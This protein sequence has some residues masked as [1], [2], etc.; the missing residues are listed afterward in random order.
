M[1]T[2]G[3]RSR[4]I[5]AAILIAMGLIQ[6]VNSMFLSAEQSFWLWLAGLLGAALALGWG[7]AQEKQPWTALAAYLV[8]GLAVLFFVTVKLNPGGIDFVITPLV[9]A[10]LP[11]VYLWLRNPRLSGWLLLGY[12]LL[13]IAG[14][15]V[16]LKVSATWVAVYV[17][18][19]LGL[20]FVVLGALSQRTYLL[21][22]FILWGVGLM[23]YLLIS[24]VSQRVVDGIGGAALIGGGL[25]LLSRIE[26][27]ERETMMHHGSR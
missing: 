27:H 1:L 17:A 7:Y 11:F 3:K 2:R 15:L 26:A 10:A 22:G 5:V 25:Y 19:V 23:Q 4:I 16:I 6:L 8:L 21:P 18:A 13:V 14:L 12:M 9:L 20:P 24:G